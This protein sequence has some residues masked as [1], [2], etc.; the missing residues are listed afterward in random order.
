MIFRKER[1]FWMKKK[2]LIALVLLACMLLTACGSTGGSTDSSSDAAVERSTPEPVEA[3][4]DAKDGEDFRNNLAAGLNARLALFNSEEYVNSHEFVDLMTSYI[5]AELDAL[6]KYE[7]Y[8]ILDKWLD[9]L[10]QRYFNALG[11]QLA[12][13][14]YADTDGIKYREYFEL[15]GY[16]ERVMVLAYLKSEYGFD[17]GETY[18]KDFDEMTAEGDTLLELKELAAQQQPVRILTGSGMSDYTAELVNVTELDLSGSYISIYPMDE[19][20]EPY[21]TYGGAAGSWKPGESLDIYFMGTRELMPTTVGLSIELPNALKTD[22]MPLSFKEAGADFILKD[23]PCEAGDRVKFRFDSVSADSPLWLDGEASLFI[24]LEGEKT[25]DAFF[26]MLQDYVDHPENYTQEEAEKYT[27]DT[28]PENLSWFLSFGTYC[29]GIGL[30][31]DCAADI[32]ANPED[33]YDSLSIFFPAA[34]FTVE[35]YSSSG[36]LVAE[37]PVFYENYAVGEK[38]RGTDTEQIHLYGLA[39]DTYTVVIKES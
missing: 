4:A 36:E 8:V 28:M 22:Y 21:D 39:P 13:M 33:Y 32:L 15:K 35:V 20:G 1:T 27:A 6:G 34:N 38:L 19:N 2:T 29:R 23:A 5:N 16:D 9:I 7:D 18:A 30:D 12:A 31:P 17:I 26:A 24:W 11:S 10:A 3:K 14:E 25:Y 37:K